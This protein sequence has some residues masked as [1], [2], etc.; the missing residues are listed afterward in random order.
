MSV[1]ASNVHLS[2]VSSHCVLFYFWVFGN[3]SQYVLTDLPLCNPAVYPASMRSTGVSWMWRKHRFRC[4]ELN[5]MNCVICLQLWNKEGETDGRILSASY[6]YSYLFREL[7]FLSLCKEIDS[8]LGLTDLLC[9]IGNISPVH[10]LLFNLYSSYGPCVLE[11]ALESE[12]W[13]WG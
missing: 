13:N 6:L 10:V 4:F 7:I 5:D 1:S 3:W 11:L 8:V 9:F 12:A 2:P